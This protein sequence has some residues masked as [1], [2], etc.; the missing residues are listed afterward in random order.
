M[1]DLDELYKKYLYYKL[2]KTIPFIFFIFVLLLIGYIYIVPFYID[3]QV[4]NIKDL[5]PKEKKIVQGSNILQD[6]KNKKEVL[7]VKQIKSITQKRAKH[8]KFFTLSVREKNRASIQKVQEKYLKLGLKCKIEKQNN[9]LNLVCGETSSYTEYRK[10]KSL[11]QKYHI[12]YYLV[13]K[14]EIPVTDLNLAK[15]N[16]AKKN[17]EVEEK[18]MAVKNI[19]KT[20]EK[21]QKITFVNISHSDVNLKLLEEK[22]SAHESY[23]IAIRI[24]NEYYDQKEYKKSL[25]WAKKA[26]HLNR[27]KRQSWI[28]YARSLYALGDT[29]KAIKILKLY[30]HFS[31][32]KE[33]DRILE[34]WIHNDK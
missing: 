31:T 11:L 14:K 7:E 25:F 8:Y 10:I 28:L 15:Q 17:I 18:Q 9:Y 19:A 13:T 6:K 27:K 20:E 30:K 34:K 1:F 33:V 16:V 2:K 3:S 22:F 24:A 12:K 4:K 26:N 29:E 23:D 21:I 32:S 5:A